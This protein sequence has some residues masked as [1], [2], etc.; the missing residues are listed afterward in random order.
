MNRPRTC[1]LL[2]VLILIVPALWAGPAFAEGP[3]TSGAGSG[4][5]DVKTATAAYLAKMPPDKKAK[6]DAYFEGGYW[7]LL[8]D[9]LYSTAVLL[10]LLNLGWSAAMRDRAERIA[11][12]LGRGLNWSRT[13]LYW[14]QM[15]AAIT[16]AQFPMV[17]YEGYYREHKYGLATQSFAPWLGDQAKAFMVN[18]ILFGILLVP[19]YLVLR[20]SRH[21]WIWGSLVSILFLAFAVVISPVYIFPIF[22]TFTRLEDKAIREPIL[23]LA[24]ANGIPAD[25]VWVVDASKQTTRVSAN[26]SGLLGTTRITINDN[27]LKRCSLQEIEA[28]MGHEM[29]HYVLHHNYK[30]VA[31]LGLITFLGF[32]FLN[33]SFGGAV[34][35]FGTKWGVRGTGDPAGLPLLM[36]LFSVYFFFLTPVTN[37]A[38]RIEEAEADLFGLNAAQQPDGAAEVALKLGDYRKMDPGGLEED[39]FFDHPS[40]RNRI[41]MAMRWK[42][43]HGPGGILCKQEG[44]AP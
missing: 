35:R 38:T 4:G 32:V 39:L 6:S 42:A 30:G 20:L 31:F 34:R 23:G 3:G 1:L 28:V 25:D 17:V 14:V 29:G 7:L 43:E 27:M 13:L 26:V 44:C 15:F 37:S 21:W 8:W 2:A 9:F 19:L 12:R 41:E 22:N 11:G 40:G 10:L 18:L 36:L 5:F 16:I 33:L 24:R